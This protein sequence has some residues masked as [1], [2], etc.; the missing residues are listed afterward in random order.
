MVDH[1][2]SNES[3]YV[4]RDLIAPIANINF[5][6]KL[7]DS[8]VNYSDEE[9][10][11]IIKADNYAKTKQKI[12]EFAVRCEERLESFKQR[13]RETEAELEAAQHRADANRP[14]SPPGELFL[15]HT[16]HNAVARHNGKVNEYNN[17]VDLHRR[18]VDQMMRSKERYEDALERFKEKKAEVEEQ[19]REKTEELKPALDSDMAAFLGKLQQ[20]VFDCFHNKAL[21]FEPFVLLLM[22]KKAYVFLYDRIENNSDRN[23]ASNTFRQLNGELETLVEKYSEELKQAFTEIVK[24]LYECFCEN[25]AIFAAMQKQIEQLP[26]DICNSNDDSAHSLASLV[27]DTNFQYK[28]IIDPNELARVE[29]RIRDRQQQFKNNI[30]EIDTFTNQITETF[31]T[32]AEV[33]ADSKTKLQLIRQNKETRMGEAFD[34]S[35]FVL[36]VFYE[37]VQDEYLK[38]QKTLLEA[39]Q[40]E[41][42]T[43]LGINLTKLIKTILETELLSV[44]AAQAIDSNTGFAFLEYRQKLQKKRQEFTGGIRTLDDQLQEISKL[45][46]EKSEEFT[47]Q[48]SNFLV[49]SVFPLANLGTLF[50][51]YQALTKFTPA[52]GSGHPVYEELREKTKSKLQGFAIAHALIAILIGSAAFAVKNDQKPFILGGAAVYT[53]S[54]GVLFL[55]KKQLTKL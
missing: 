27:V 45:P 19:V 33:L 47:K 50:P 3:L 16:D 15:D 20:L 35:R 34:Y 49:I 41:I 25:E 1:I 11:G 38:Q 24:Y 28:D 12:Q 46:Q 18:L 8:G 21:I 22:A 29:A 10:A 42:E 48:M 4:V 13:L 23:T 55:Q 36:G 9:L 26:Y 37:E 2:T 43:A 7:G 40:L 31:D 32:I 53:V 17:K 44:S 5:F 6:I 51:V 39:M 52:L 54:G 14:G 30:T